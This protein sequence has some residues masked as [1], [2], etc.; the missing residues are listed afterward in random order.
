MSG[1]NPVASRRLKVLILKPSSLGD[2]IHGLPVLR[3]LK[4]SFPHAEIHWWVEEGFAQIFEGDPDLGKIQIFRRRNWQNLAGVLAELGSAW[5]LRDE[6]YDWVIDL[7]GLARSAWFGWFVGGK[8]II[9]I[10]SGREG[11]RALYDVIVHRNPEEKHAVDWFLDVARALG[12][13]CSMDYEWLPKRSG[14]RDSLLDSQSKWVVFCP[15]ARWPNKRWP[16]E[17]FASLA[18]NLQLRDN[19]LRIAIVGNSGDA[20]LSRT[21]KE[22]APGICMDLSGKTTFTELFECLRNARVV[23]AND[24]GPLHVAAALNR[25]LVALYGP[26]HSGR[27][28][29]YAYPDSIMS[30]A[31]SCA[32]CQV[33]CCV[34][35]IER[36]CMEAISP[37]AVADAVMANL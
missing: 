2:I 19:Q 13:V 36:E 6:K 14:S 25:P 34:N 15:G 12:A 24:S 29:P 18:A 27:T 32:P 26:T 37:D 30:A 33:P 22:A 5:K 1:S 3:V 9:G 7:Q 35:E 21:I 11:A 20:K 4:S 10:D 28:G 17:H 31:V 16:A 8:L 23:V